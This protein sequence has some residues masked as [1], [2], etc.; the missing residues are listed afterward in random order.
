MTN[1]T[2]VKQASAKQLKWLRDLL[3]D[4]DYTSFPADWQK[5]CDAIKARFATLDAD[6][7]GPE[8]INVDLITEGKDPITHDDFQRLLP[9]LQ[10][11]PKVAKAGGAVQESDSPIATTDGIFKKGDTF[12]KLRFAKTGK[13]WAHRLVFL[14]TPEQAK[15][16]AAA[17][18]KDHA[19]KF[20]FAGSPQNLGIREDMKLTYEDMKAFGALYNTCCECGR[21]LTNDLSVALGIGPVCGGRLFGGEF[22]FMISQAKLEVEAAK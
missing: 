18:S 12:F 20:K 2:M 22:K 21:L 9:K 14:M 6:G 5:V 10:A 17:G 16:A 4:K 15:A 3:N 1:G 19:V 7:Y 8:A 13:L 11:A